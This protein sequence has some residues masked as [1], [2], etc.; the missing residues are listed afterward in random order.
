MSVQIRHKTLINAATQAI[1][2]ENYYRAHQSDFLLKSAKLEN[3]HAISRYEL[4]Q[5]NLD[6]K[7]NELCFKGKITLL[8][9]SSPFL[10]RSAEK[11]LESLPYL[12]LFLGN[13]RTGQRGSLVVL[14]SLIKI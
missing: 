3:L 2:F 12:T 10:Q 13:I 11:R 5:C 8:I 7:T 1:V 14:V 4:K 6:P 9:L